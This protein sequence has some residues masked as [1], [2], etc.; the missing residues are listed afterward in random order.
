MSH[1]FH[2]HFI[3]RL[4]KEFHHFASDREVRLAHNLTKFVQQQQTE[5]NEEKTRVH[6][7]SADDFI[8]L[9]IR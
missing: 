3:N 2:P 8:K 6:L 4:P 5:F 1:A 9:R 7:F